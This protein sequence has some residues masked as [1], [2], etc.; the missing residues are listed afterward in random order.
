MHPLLRVLDQASSPETEATSVHELHPVLAAAPRGPRALP[1]TL[2][3]GLTALLVLGISQGLFQAPALQAQRALAGAG[4]TVA[5]LLAEPLDAAGRRPPAPD[6]AGPVLAGGA[7]HREGSST[8]DP[9]LAQLVTTTPRASDALDPDQLGPLPTADRAILPLLDP[10][11][12]RQAGGNGLAAGTGRDPMQG[13]GARLQPGASVVGPDNQLVP[14]RQVTLFH[15]LAPG[16]AIL[17]RQPVRVRLYIDADGVPFR[18]AVLSGPDFLREDAVK[19]ARQW[20][21]EPLAPHGLQAPL[22]MVLTFY[23]KFL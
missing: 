7:G 6:R 21:F 10:A 22:T 13:P 16:E 9:R 11:L 18:V 1:F 8:L 3:L 12:P 17:A 15:R 20:R 5:I 23:P 4:R 2:S 19:A 14:L